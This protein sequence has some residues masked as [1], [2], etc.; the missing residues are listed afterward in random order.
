[1][2][3]NEAQEEISLAVIRVLLS[4][5]ESFPEDG[6]K[7]RNAPFHEAFLN[8][9]SDRLDKKIPTM[10]YLISLSSWLHGL[11]TSLGQSFFERVAHV[12]INGEK[13]AFTKEQHMLLKV[14]T[15]QKEIISDIITDLKNGERLPSLE[16]EETLLREMATQ[17]KVVDANNFTADVFLETEKDIVA[18]ELKTVKPNAGI[19][20]GEKQKILEAKSALLLKYPNKSINFFVGFPFDPYSQTPTGYDKTVFLD[21]IIDGKKYFALDEILLSGELWEFLS[22]E[23][24]AM[25]Q[26]LEI[27]NDVATPDFMK[28]YFFLKNS[29]NR[30]KNLR[31]YKNLLQKWH[32]YSELEL[33]N[34]HDFLQEN[35][36]YRQSVFSSAGEYKW[37]RYGKLIRLLASDK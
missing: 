34:K 4:R 25:Q 16:R 29:I 32:L 3:S 11:S 19:M 15:K 28:N 13:R 1:M 36:M 2:F 20:R 10:P 18:I 8:A 24:G 7:N 35:K 22:G 37:K 30:E 9:F 6:T 17:G 23:A 5:F 14:T 27:I 33:F 12:L 31:L 21:M 26:I